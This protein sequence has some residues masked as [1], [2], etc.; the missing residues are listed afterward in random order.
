MAVDVDEGEVFFGGG[1]EDF[2]GDA[3]D[4]ASWGDDGVLGDDGAGGDDGVGADVGSLRTVAPMP[5]RT[6][7]SM[8]QPWTV[9]LWP[10][11]T[12]SR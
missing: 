1:A 12:P 3:G 5:M 10:M 6:L 11:V 7:S 9:A 2:A 4:E 8:V